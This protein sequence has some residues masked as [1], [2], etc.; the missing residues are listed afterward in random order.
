MMCV[1][2]GRY[3]AEQEEI[4]LTG[5]NAQRFVKNTP[6]LSLITDGVFSVIDLPLVLGNCV[7]KTLLLGEPSTM[8]WP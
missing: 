8:C 4:T 7:F 2:K 1:R 5:A 3:N 6:P